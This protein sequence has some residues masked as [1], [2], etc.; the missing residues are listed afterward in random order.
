MRS[1]A[2]AVLLLLLLCP[3]LQA[4]GSSDYELA[5][6]M[7]KEGDT[8]EAVKAARAA[9]EKDPDY[10]ED[11]LT[12]GVKRARAEARPLMERVRHACGLATIKGGV[13]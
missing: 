8:G 12:E 3:L 10:V 2:L 11:V 6:L 13:S 7:W 1:T 5:R 4:G 9:L